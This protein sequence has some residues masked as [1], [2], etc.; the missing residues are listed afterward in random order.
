MFKLFKKLFKKGI[1][2]QNVNINTYINL[3]SNL[4]KLKNEHVGG[5]KINITS[6]VIII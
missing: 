5:E 3:P 6:P 2:K 1:Y 4:F